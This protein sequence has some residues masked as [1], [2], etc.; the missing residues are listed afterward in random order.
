MV[1]RKAVWASIAALALFVGSASAQ[2]PSGTISGR[3]VDATGLALPGVTVEVQGVDITQTYVTDGEGHYRFLELA[4]GIYKVTSS[5][6]GFATHERDNVVLDFGKTVD[7]A[8]TMQLSSMKETV[9]VVAPSPMVDAK[10]MGTAT[11][12][13]SDE[14]ANI[15]TSRDPFALM[16]S[17]PG[18]LVDRVNIGGNETGQQSSFASKGTRPQDAI[19]TLDGVAITDMTLTGSSPTYFNYD[20]FDAIHVTTAGQAIT[21]QTGGVGMNF[22]VKRGTNMFHGGVR[23]YFDN[24]AMEWSNVPA[25][26]AAAG[27]TPE[28]ADHNKRISDFGVD[29]GG[30]LLR[31]K[32]WFYGSYSVQ[33]VRLVRRTGSLVDRTQLKNPNVKVNWQASKKDMVSFLYF[34]GS[35]IKDNRS[36]GTAGITIDAPTATFHQDNAYTDFPLHGLWKL[37]DD[38]VVSSNTFLSAKYAYYNTGFMLTPEGGMN[39]SSGR[40]LPSARSYGSTVQSQNIRPQMSVN[41]DLN[42]FFNKLGTHDIKY[43]FG[44]RRVNSTTTTIW[45]GNGILAVAQTPT[46]LIA[47]VFREGAGTNRTVYSNFYLGDTISRGRSTIDLGVRY[48]QQGGT[49]LAS[50]TNGNPAFPSLVPGINFAGYDAP[51]TWKNLSPRAGYTYALDEAHKTVARASYSQFAGQLDSSSVGYMNPSSSAGVAV[52]RWLDPNG[53]HLAS[54]DEVQL[55]QYLGAAN[56]FNPAN[57]T[58]VTSANRINPD[59]EAP[60][61]RSVVAGLDHELRANLAVGVSYTYT[62]TS[63]LLG[64]ATFSVTPRVGMTLADYTPG[65]TLTGTLPDGAAYSVPTFI[66]DPAKVAAGGNGF[67]LTNWDGFTTDYHGVELNAVKRLSNRWM[68]RIGIAFNNAREH[69]EP[70][71]RYD[72]NGNPTPTTT[73]ALVDGG[74]FAPLSSGNSGGQVFLNS[75]WQINAN[76]MYQAAYGIEVSGNVFGRQGYPFPIFRTQSLGADTGMQVLVTPEIDTFRYDNVWNTDLRVARSFRFRAMNLRVIGDLFNV[77]NANTVLIRNNNILSTQFNTIAQNLSPR[78]FRAGVVVGF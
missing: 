7:L 27:V 43:G 39:L 53:D 3:V 73:E 8:V 10:H 13:T 20:N 77:M 2:T 32:A 75:T 22:V 78:I 36:P 9:T 49:A 24:E 34:N 16:R 17:V 12:F 47:Q 30:P 42:S 46:V 69:Y 6:A 56:G 55:N 26:L 76:A 25:E 68:G 66:P 70:Q 11:N 14:L 74:V 21:Q 1:F 67:L 52:Y 33:D 41:L 4:P 19:W 31:D 60:V 50:V 58:A 72:T 45:P 64:N 63:D 40:D 18:V 15:P 29:L 54:A 57:P 71:A 51:F 38:R 37:A 23:G 61:T 28:T 5:L 48:D 35:K 59:L 65:P 44:W 62:R